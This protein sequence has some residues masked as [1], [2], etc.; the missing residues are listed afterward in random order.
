MTYKV[1]KSLK[2]FDFWSGAI[3]NAKNLTDEEFDLIENYLE[4]SGELMTETEIN[5]FFWFDMEFWAIEIL[6][7]TEDEI[8]NRK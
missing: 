4:E 6:G 5:D 7:T 3:A 2:D 8:L 1:E